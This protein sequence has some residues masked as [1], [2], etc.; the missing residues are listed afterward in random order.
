MSKTATVAAPRLP[1]FLNAALP[2]SGGEIKFP[3]G[4]AMAG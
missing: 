2:G 1:G 4:S 3:G